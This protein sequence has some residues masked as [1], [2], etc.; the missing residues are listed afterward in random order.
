MFD[1]ELYLPFEGDLDGHAVV[2][3]L[4]RAVHDPD[5]A[6]L[7][8]DLLVEEHLL[9]RGALVHYVDLCYDPD[10]AL[11]G[12]VP[13]PCE[14]QPVGGGEVLVCGD[15]AE[16]YSFWVLAVEP[17]H[18]SCNLLDILLPLDVDAGDAGQVDDAQVGAVY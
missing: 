13:F 16:D 3:V 10:R 8:E 6:Q 9:G 15:D 1:E 18:F 4:L 5:V 11:P 14:F 12:F 17:C 7:E 2:Y